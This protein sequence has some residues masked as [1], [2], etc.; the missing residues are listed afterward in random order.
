MN[1]WGSTGYCWCV[2][3][4]G[5]EIEET[6]Q[7]P[8]EGFPDCE[9]IDLGDINGDDSVD[10]LDIV[11]LVNYILSGDTSEL[12]GADINNDGTINIQDIVVT[13]NLVLSG[14]YNSSADLNSDG[15][16]DVLD[17]IVLVNIILSN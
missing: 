8:S 6:S 12:D 2:D 9:E 14:Q 16:V 1:C 10:I 11:I 15:T 5:V 17:I 3:E 7:P 4:N 13:I